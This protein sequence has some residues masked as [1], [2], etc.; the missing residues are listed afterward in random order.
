MNTVV[1]V[2]IYTQGNVNKGSSYDSQMFPS[3]FRWKKTKQKQRESTGQ[4]RG[5]T[6]KK[7]WEGSKHCLFF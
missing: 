4:K 7:N 2:V 6:G 1:H 5:R 3:L